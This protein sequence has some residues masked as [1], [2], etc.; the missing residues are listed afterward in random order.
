MAIIQ[1]ADIVLA[2]HGA[3]F[4]NFLFLCKGTVVIEL[5]PFGFFWPYLDKFISMA[6]ASVNRLCMAPEHN[7]FRKCI[8]W[9]AGNFTEAFNEYKHM[10]KRYHL[11]VNMTGDASTCML[12]NQF[13]FSCTRWQPAVFDPARVASVVAEH[14]RTMCNNRNSWNFVT[15]WVHALEIEILLNLTTSLDLP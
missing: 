8:Q 9:K 7:R 1:R 4:F 12:K 11:D 13:G 10:A 6:G 2:V 14:A 5:S 15:N 3:E